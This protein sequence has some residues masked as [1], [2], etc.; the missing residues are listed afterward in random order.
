MIY[1]SE[2]NQEA[3]LFDLDLMKREQWRLKT[4][5]KVMYTDKEKFQAVNDI[6]KGGICFWFSED[7]ISG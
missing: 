4:E 3:T 1:F 6:F 5:E 7:W 2:Q